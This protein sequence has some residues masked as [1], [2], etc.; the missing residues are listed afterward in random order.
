MT[1]PNWTRR[2]RKVALAASQR[3]RGWGHSAFRFARAKLGL[4]ALLL[5]A[6]AV[7]L[8]VWS[9]INF[10]DWLQTGPDGPES[11]STTVRNLG[12]VIGGVAAILLAVWRSRV[13]ER[14][15]ETAQ[16]SL[17]NERYQQGAEM[18]GSGVL[19]V[20]L[21][22]IYALR[23]LAEDHPEHYHIEIM[24]LFCAFVRNPTG[25]AGGSNWKDS[26]GR[27][28]LEEI[29][30]PQL[31]E[32]VQSIM[33]G[34]GSRS[35]MVIDLETKKGFTLDLRGADL[36]GALLQYS[37]LSGADLN[38]ADLSYAVLSK[39]DLS[40]SR[41]GMFLPNPPTN[42]LTQ[43]QIDQACADPGNPP[44]LGGIVDDVTQEP[45]VWRGKPL[46]PSE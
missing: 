6:A 11:G 37:D 9:L 43:H 32:D 41:F 33:D 16:R 28:P 44:D 14:Q 34:I 31:R 35:K 25:E 19:S 42:G 4:L 29:D 5:L 13:A 26:R 46:D 21:G 27:D 45:L 30:G 7:A 12:L 1:L 38:R 23:R 22:G 8:G 2:A 18:L 39:A 17:L 3:S 15:A 24:K 36:R 10:W 40:G 20:R